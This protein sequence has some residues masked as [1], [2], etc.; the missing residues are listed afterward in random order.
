[1]DLRPVVLEGRLVRLVPLAFTN[2]D[3]LWEVARDPDLWQISLS[4]MASKDDLAR[5]VAEALEEQARGLALPFTTVWQADDRPIGSTRFGNITPAHRRIEIG[6]TWVGRPW[7]RS[8]AN[9]EAKL[10]MLRYAF[11]TW[12]VM[13]VELKTNRLN[14]RS[15][16][17]MLA[18]GAKEEGILRHHMIN[19]DGS[20][21]DTVFYSILENEW[22]AV[23]IGLEKRLA[24]GR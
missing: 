20:L 24:N 22:P 11:E 8:G 9:V 14:E 5:Y 7:Q 2:V 1:M 23:R 4:K 10:L 16:G 17:A 12:R 19:E 18:L 3:A 21:R 6:W 15:R 13:R